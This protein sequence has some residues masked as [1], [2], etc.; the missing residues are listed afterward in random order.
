MVL[1]AVVS[2]EIDQVIKFFLERREAE[3]M[4]ARVLDDEPGWAEILRIEPIELW[5]GTAN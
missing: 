4:L 1:W 5:T 3:T 2:D